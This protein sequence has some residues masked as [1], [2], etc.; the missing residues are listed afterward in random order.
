MIERIT[1]AQ[2]YR[3]PGFEEMIAE[4]SAHAI[5]SLPKPLY[6]EEDYTK[7]EALGILAVWCAMH[8]GNVVGFATCLSS[9]I[10]HYGIGIAIAESLF[11]RKGSR[12]LGLG[13]RLISAVERHSASLGAPAV[14]F[15]CPIGSGYDKVLLH[16]HYSAETTTYVKALI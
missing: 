8:D 16:R 1:V 9:M 13:I 11:V 12:V 4:Y 10:P 6:R 3:R 15:S 5:K 2:L 7:L 14:F